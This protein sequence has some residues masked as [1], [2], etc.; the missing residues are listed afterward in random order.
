MHSKPVKYVVLIESG[1]VIT[2]RLFDAERTQVGFIDGSSG[3]VASMTNGV[4]PLV[5]EINDP[6]WREPLA[7][8]SSSERRTARL[9][10]LNP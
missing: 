2:A 6:L 7:A 5:I 8:H 4:S 10:V 1:G 9:F 3:E